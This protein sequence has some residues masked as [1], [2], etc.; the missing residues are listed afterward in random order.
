MQLIANNSSWY[1][2]GY[3]LYLHYDFTCG[4][5]VGVDLST[6]FCLTYP[7]GITAVNNFTTSNIIRTIYTTSA[8]YRIYS[9]STYCK[10]CDRIGNDLTGNNF[11]Y[12]A[13][14]IADIQIL[15]N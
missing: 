8:D 12:S 10:I 3:T 5:P 4:I 7:S 6:V 11:S 2:I 9:G 15:V 14:F 13:P 1:R